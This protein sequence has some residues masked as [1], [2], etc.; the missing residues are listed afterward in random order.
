MSQ[1]CPE[2]F[3]FSVTRLFYGRSDLTLRERI[4]LGKTVFRG[5]LRERTDREQQ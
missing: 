5:L 4:T 3:G 2:Q 1:Q